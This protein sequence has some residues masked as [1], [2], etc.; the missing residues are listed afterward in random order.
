MDIREISLIPPVGDFVAK[1]EGTMSRDADVPATAWGRQ[2]ERLQRA[3]IWAPIWT[4]GHFVFVRLGVASAID[5]T[6]WAA[7]L[8]GLIIGYLWEAALQWHRTGRAKKRGLPARREETPE[9]RFVLDHK[10]EFKALDELIKA[11]N[12]ALQARQHADAL[13]RES[14]PELHEGDVESWNQRKIS[15][16]AGRQ[17]LM[18]GMHAAG[19]HERK[20][21]EFRAKV[22]DLL[23]LEAGERALEEGGYHG[24][25]S[26]NT[27]VTPIRL[28]E[29]LE[30]ERNYL[31]LPE[32]ELPQ[33]P[34][35]KKK[36]LRAAT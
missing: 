19:E 30:E 16:S 11:F 34:K 10:D 21:Q 7:G 13:V 18:D 31:G 14:S 6:W 32:K 24:T 3:A 29:M 25:I 5:E 12:T 8:R 22:K 9:D 27:L 26:V 15:I 28:R 33:M 36:L 2:K 1:A 17:L 35:T 20:I 23:A 4:L